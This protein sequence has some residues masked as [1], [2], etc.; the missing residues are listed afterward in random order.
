LVCDVVVAKEVRM[1]K[2]PKNEPFLRVPDSGSSDSVETR[3]GEQ[4]HDSRRSFLL[5]SKPPFL[6]LPEMRYQDRYVWL[7]LV[8][9][10]DIILTMLVLY[11]WDGHEVNPVAHAVISHMG[12]V[13][14]IG[15]KFGIVVLVILVCELI[16]RRSDREGRRLATAAI[17]INAAPV[18]YTFLLLFAAAPP[19]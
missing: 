14:A 19:G 10:L 2:Q 7:V 17:I 3:E 11:A 6:S 9:A 5:P 16:G 4:P 15:L 1:T 13:G 18:A 8:S 12:F